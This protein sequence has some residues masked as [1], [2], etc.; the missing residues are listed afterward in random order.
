MNKF[1][2]DEA[3]KILMNEI[4]PV[5]LA[6]K[7][8]KLKEMVIEDISK[9]SKESSF[10]NIV[11]LID[12]YK[13]KA[14]HAI[15]KIQ[16][17]E[18]KRIT[19]NRYLPEIIKA[20][21]AIYIIEQLNMMAK[22]GKPSEK[23][24]LNL[25]DGFILQKILFKKDLERKPASLFYFKLFWPFITNKKILMPLVNKK[26]IYCFYS[27]VFIR[28]L[29]TIIGDSKCVEIGAGDGTLTRFLNDIGI[30][31]KATDD[32]SWKHYIH[33]PD[34]VE[35][36]D[37]KMALKKY[38]PETVICSWAPPGNAF[39]RFVFEMDS[40]KTYIVIGTKNPLFSGN[41][42]TYENQKKFNMEYDYR[43]STKVLPQ[44]KDNMVYIFKRKGI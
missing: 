30:A 29:A 19:L 36:M 27:K 33:Y 18:G 8:P 16:K 7:Y 14:S 5:M 15:A 2:K 25:W 35:N 22:S 12:S 23:I 17:S 13:R 11:A 41:H 3:Y 43:L 34:F 42:V 4:E 1:S 39:E 44:S 20:R 38:K 21:I 26:G 6:D 31:C 37:A 10:E 24:R 28:K 32:Y 40:V 9:T